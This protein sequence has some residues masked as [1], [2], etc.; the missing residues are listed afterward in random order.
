[1]TNGAGVIPDIVTD[2][3]TGF[4][5]PVGDY[6][7]LAAR[8]LQLLADESIATSMT[9]RA[10]AECARY[11]WAVVCPQWLHVYHSLAQK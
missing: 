2:E 6:E 4:V 5:V 8:A 1:M 7:S 10:R 11:T 9:E 3:V